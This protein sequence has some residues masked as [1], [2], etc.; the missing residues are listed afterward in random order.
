MCCRVI[1]GQE[2]EKELRQHEELSSLVWICTSTHS[3]TKVMV[4]DANQPGHILENFFVCN[5]HVLCIASVPGLVAVEVPPIM[6]VPQI[7]RYELFMT[8]TPEHF[9]IW[10]RRPRDGLPCRGGGTTGA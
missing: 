2:Q 10:L 4:V 7:D 8:V 1:G 5:S 6:T 3:T 9:V